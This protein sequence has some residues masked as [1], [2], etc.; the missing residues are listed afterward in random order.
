[1]SA[2]DSASVKSL[3]ENDLVSPRL[4]PNQG[5]T[6]LLGKL[7]SITQQLQLFEGKE[8]KPVA[9]K[10]HELA[11]PVVSEVLDAI[12]SDDAAATLIGE[13]FQHVSNMRKGL[14]GVSAWQL[15]AWMAK[16]PQ[17]FM[18][19][20]RLFCALHGYEPPQRKRQITIEQ[21]KT[22]LVKRALKNDLVLQ[23]LLQDAKTEFGADPA[24]VI[25]TLAAPN[26]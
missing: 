22:L 5:H 7:Q 17:A 26:L 25:F 23:A 20:A 13:H 4:V 11:S 18:A 10:M 19:F 15:I 3:P 2:D 21:L 1:M 24:D 9:S 12:D 8:T 6:K 14:R 16:W